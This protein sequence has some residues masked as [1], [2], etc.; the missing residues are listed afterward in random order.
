VG[1]AAARASPTASGGWTSATTPWEARAAAVPVP[2]AP[3]LV[4]APNARASTTQLN[5]LSTVLAEV[6]STQS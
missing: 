1:K 5:S 6:N 3:T 2:M 4:V